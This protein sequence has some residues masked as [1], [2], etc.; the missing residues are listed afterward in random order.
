MVNK[1]KE[2]WFHISQF[3]LRCSM[4]FTRSSTAKLTFAFG[5]ASQDYPEF[6]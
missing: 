3:T 1:V 6:D 2:T 5:F 4:M